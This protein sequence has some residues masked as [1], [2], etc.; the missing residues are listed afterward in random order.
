MGVGTTVGVIGGGLASAGIGAGAALSAAGTQADAAKNAAQLQFKLGQESLD[1]QKQQ[2]ATN[3]ANFAPW[4]TAGRNAL[5]TLTGNLAELTAPF[6]GTFTAPT[7]GEAAANPAYQFAA[8][9]GSGAIENSAAAGGNL[10]STGSAKTLAQ[11]NQGLASQT[12]NDVYNRAFN[13]YLTKYNI[14]QGNQANAFNRL[15]A[16]SGVGQTA[17]NTLGTLGQSASSNVANINASTGQQ[18]GNSL[19]LAG[20]ATASGYAGLANAVNGGI[21]SITQSL[22]LQSLL[23][24]QN[25][26][27][28]SGSNSGT[29]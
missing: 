22:L 3:Q 7:A 10:L 16:I 27:N 13:E 1:F 9:A 24:Q 15:A 29:I 17:A 26:A 21:G 5:S 12:Y 2:F 23:N 25:N 6:T 4:L 14:F 20:A 19:N 28:S 18:V 8:G 11:Y